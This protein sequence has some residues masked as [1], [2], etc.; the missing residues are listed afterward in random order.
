MHI[1]KSTY[2]HS[3]SSAKLGQVV[4]RS[5]EESDDAITPSSG[6]FTAAGKPEAKSSDTWGR[7]RSGGFAARYVGMSWV[8]R[9]LQRIQI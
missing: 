4:V 9:H 5:M 2:L 1:E 7:R 8:N 3:P 6:A